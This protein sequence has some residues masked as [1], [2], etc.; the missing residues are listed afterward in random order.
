[1]GYARIHVDTAE[2]ALRIKVTPGQPRIGSFSGFSDGHL[3]AREQVRRTLSAIGASNG[4]L[5][6]WVVLGNG[7]VSGFAEYRNTRE[8]RAYLRLELGELGNGAPEQILHSHRST[9]LGRRKCGVE[10]DVADVA[11]RHG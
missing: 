4:Q 9:H 3:R 10:R 5:L 7:S 11:P 1:M 2:R 6:S 8:G